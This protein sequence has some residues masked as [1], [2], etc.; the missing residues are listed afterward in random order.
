[1]LRVTKRITGGDTLQRESIPRV[2]NR[3]P[4]GRSPFKKWR[5]RGVVTEIKAAG[6]TE[7]RFSLG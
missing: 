5:A 6:L 3:K 4:R 1:M 7:A 2:S